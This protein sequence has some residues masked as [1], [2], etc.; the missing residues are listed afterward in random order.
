M[1]ITFTSKAEK[2]QFIWDMCLSHEISQ[3]LDKHMGCH[4]YQILR[5]R[6]EA[7]G[8]VEMTIED[9]LPWPA[10]SELERAEIEL[11]SRGIN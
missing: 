2:D 4:S 11:K 5:D 1:R 3:R 9:D 8:N 7:Y 10:P 6:L